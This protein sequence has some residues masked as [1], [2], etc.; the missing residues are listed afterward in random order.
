MSSLENVGKESIHTYICFII[1]FF[2]VKDKIFKDKGG[3]AW[4]ISFFI[5]SFILQF[6]SNLY[7]TQNP[8]VCGSIQ[9]TS[10][11]KSTLFP[12]V[13]IMGLTIFFLM[14][15]PGWLRPF[16][17]TFG[18]MAANYYGLKKVLV[19]AFS[20][21]NKEGAN[22]ITTNKTGG[23]ETLSDNKMKEL[24]AIN[25]IYDDP[26]TF[27]NDLDSGYTV[28]KIKNNDWEKEYP[29]NNN[30]KYKPEIIKEDEQY[31]TVRYWNGAKF[32]IDNKSTKIIDKND[33]IQK[34]EN[35]YFLK[36]NVAYFIWL[37]LTGI[38]SVLVSTNTLLSESCIVSK[39]DAEAA[40]SKIYE[41]IEKATS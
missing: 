33:S 5:L 30:G 20:E 9:F 18:L 21:E 8:N 13:F 39:T 37:L 3:F 15:F 4:L 34:I 16:S 7:I 12:W 2:L 22:I 17:N 11:F 25:F 32:I 38:I 1:L 35:M 28:E 27:I 31:T 14:M 6:F 10:S 29:G 19:E 36:E 24:T 41:P 23:N 40:F 26:T